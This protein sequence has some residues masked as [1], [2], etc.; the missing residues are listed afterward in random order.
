MMRFEVGTVEYHI[1]LGGVLRDMYAKGGASLLAQSVL[2]K[3]PSHGCVLECSSMLKNG[4]GP[5]AR[6]CFGTNAVWAAFLMK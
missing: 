1:V 5:Q 2:E 3:L 4:Q 6:D